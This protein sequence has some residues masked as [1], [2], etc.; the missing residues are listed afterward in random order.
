[1]EEE[2]QATPLLPNCSEHRVDLL[3]E[4]N[5]A[6]QDEGGIDFS[7]KW[8]H[9]RLGLVI[10]VGDAEFGAGIAKVLS[11]GPSQAVLVGDADN[12]ALAPRQINGFHDMPPLPIGLADGQGPTRSLSLAQ[13]VCYAIW[14][15][16]AEHCCKA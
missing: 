2:I 13:N 14:P 5:I 3:R 11:C 15:S 8:F 4:R 6:G 10:A 1:M 16:A 9:Q 7:R 12:Q